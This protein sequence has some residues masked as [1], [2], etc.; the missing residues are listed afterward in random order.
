GAEEEELCTEEDIVL[1]YYVLEILKAKGLLIY[2]TSLIELIPFNEKFQ[3]KDAYYKEPHQLS[4]FVVCRPHEGEILIETPLSPV[5]VIIKDPK[6][7]QLI[8]VLKSP[9]EISEI[10][11]NFPDIPEQALQKTLSL[12]AS[13][14]IITHLP[15][16]D[17]SAQW[18]HH[19][20][21]F[22]T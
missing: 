10:Q 13:A 21:F 5:R 12:L 1:S 8:Y 16:I 11:N 15:E 4:R 3:F 14:Q 6:A 19:D 7:L 9:L 17:A 22:H 18:E 2:K 20:I